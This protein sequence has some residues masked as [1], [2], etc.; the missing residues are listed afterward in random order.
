MGDPAE[1]NREVDHPHF[2]SSDVGD[3]NFSACEGELGSFHFDM[4]HHTDAIG[5]AADTSTL[6]SHG[7][8]AFFELSDAAKAFCV[9]DY[10]SLDKDDA[11]AFP[12]VDDELLMGWVSPRISFSQDLPMEDPAAPHTSRAF[13]EKRKRQGEETGELND[14]YSSEFEFLSNGAINDGANEVRQ[15]KEMML[16]A[17]ELFS[18]GKLLPMQVQ[19]IASP[20]G[21]LDLQGSKLSWLHERQRGESRGNEASVHSIKLTLHVDE[22]NASEVNERLMSRHLSL[23]L[24]R[25]N[26][27][28]TSCGLVVLA[29]VSVDNSPCSSPPRSSA[30]PNACTATP[31]AS[32]ALQKAG[33]KYTSKF[34]DFFK[35]KR[36]SSSISPQLTR[37]NSTTS[38]S[39]CRIPIPPRSF[40]PFS[41]SNSAGESKTALPSLPPRSNSAG[42]R[43]TSR[44]VAKKSNNTRILELNRTS[45]ISNGQAA[46]MVPASEDEFH[47]SAN[48]YMD[49][50]STRNCIDIGSSSNCT[51]AA[52]KAN[53]EEDCAASSSSQQT[54]TSNGRSRK[55]KASGSPGRA[56]RKRYMYTTANFLRGS[57]GRRGGLNSAVKTNTSRIVLKN[58]ERCSAD[59]KLCRETSGRRA[60]AYPVA[61]RV[62]PVINVA[63]YRGKVPSSGMFGLRRLFSSKKDKAKEKD[64]AVN[65]WRAGA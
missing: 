48:N 54:P 5:N 22:R 36:V 43:N 55:G 53:A 58:L 7:V 31:S 14:V 52:K 15:T 20:I 40:W 17:D 44:I 4:G 18:D 1:L 49:V 16:S 30:P 56:A 35:P 24:P 60:V 3:F 13:P 2:R 9:A 64:A 38:I 59:R 51:E 45:C 12:E 25:P 63:V 11:H 21:D 19:E 39:T 10:K 33:S 50:N 62:S 46:A 41:R 34:K 57:P 26:S 6:A 65:N 27:S 23:D 61:L 32:P 42:D 28:S 37:D 29:S 47:I 8:E